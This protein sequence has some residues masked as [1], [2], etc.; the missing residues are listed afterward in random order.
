VTRALKELKEQLAEVHDLQRALGVLGW[1][2]RTMMPALGGEYRSQQ[3][4]TLGRITH[5]RFVS[6]DIGRL[7][8]ELR[9]HEESLHPD[10]ASSRATSPTTSSST[11]TSPG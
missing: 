2:Q 8:E 11:T 3:L 7:L 5:E 4:G 1:D 10:S 6:D 9:P